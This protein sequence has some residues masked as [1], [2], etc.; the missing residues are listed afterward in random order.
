M[1]EVNPNVEAPKPI[2]SISDFLDRPVKLNISRTYSGIVVTPPTTWAGENG[3][4]RWDLQRRVKTSTKDREG[5]AFS[6]FLGNR[7]VDIFK[8]AWNEG[9][10]TAKDIVRDPAV[11]N[12]VKTN[13]FRFIEAGLDKIDG[14]YVDKKTEPPKI[15][16]Q[17]TEKQKFDLIALIYMKVVDNPSVTNAQGVVEPKG[18]DFITKIITKY[19]SE[20]N[21]YGS[22]GVN[23]QD[24]DQ[25][26]IGLNIATRKALDIYLLAKNNRPLQ[27]VF[28]SLETAMNKGKPVYAKDGKGHFIKKDGKKVPT[29][30]ASPKT[31]LAGAVSGKKP[32]ETTASGLMANMETTKEG[33]KVEVPSLVRNTEKGAEVKSAFLVD[34]I[35][36]KALDVLIP[37]AEMA[38][39]QEY[40]YQAI[41]ANNPDYV[42][43]GVA[44]IKYAKARQMWDTALLDY[45]GFKRDM[46]GVDSLANDKDKN[47]THAEILEI[48]KYTIMIGRRAVEL[49]GE[50]GKLGEMNPIE[51]NKKKTVD[52]V[53]ALILQKDASTQE[54]SLTKEAYRLAKAENA[55]KRSNTKQKIDEP[56]PEQVQA[57]KNE[58]VGEIRK[59]TY[60]LL[61]QKRKIIDRKGERPRFKYDKSLQEL[62]NESGILS[63][64]DSK[65]RKL[66]YTALLNGLKLREDIQPAVDSNP[67]D[68]YN[69][70]LGM[71]LIAVLDKKEG[72]YHSLADFTF[73]QKRN[74]GLK[75]KDYVLRNTMMRETPEEEQFGNIKIT[76]GKDGKPHVELIPAK[77][78]DKPGGTIGQEVSADASLPPAPVVNRENENAEKQKKLDEQAVRVAKVLNINNIKDRNGLL[79]ELKSKGLYK[80]TDIQTNETKIK[81]SI[82]LKTIDVT[83]AVD[84]ATLSEIS[85]LFPEASIKIDSLNLTLPEGNDKT[86][87]TLKNFIVGNLTLS[88]SSAEGQTGFI[89]LERSAVDYIEISK[90]NFVV[91]ID[92]AAPIQIDVKNGAIIDLVASSD[93]VL[94][95]ILTDDNANPK[96]IFKFNDKDNAKVEVVSEKDEVY[97]DVSD[98]GASSKNKWERSQKANGENILVNENGVYILKPKPEAKKAPKPQPAK[99]AEPISQTVSTSVVTEVL[100]VQPT[101][102]ST[103]SAASAKPT[104]SAPSAS[105][106]QP[107]PAPAPQPPPI[108]AAS[109]GSPAPAASSAPSAKADDLDIPGFLRNRRA[110]PSTPTPPVPASAAPAA[111]GAKSAEITVGGNY[112][113]AQLQPRDN[114]ELPDGRK[115]IVSLENGEMVVRYHG[116]IVEDINLDTELK[117]LKKAQEEVKKAQKEVEEEKAGSPGDE[118]VSNGDDVSVS[119]EE[120]IPEWLETLYDGNK[121]GQA[122][123]NAGSPDDESTSVK[124]TADVPETDDVGVQ[125]RTLEDEN[126]ATQPKTMRSVLKSLK[127]R[128]S[129]SKTT[130][131]KPTPDTSSAK[132]LNALP[133]EEQSFFGT[134]LT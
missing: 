30:L 73:D 96:T 47:F 93:D 67:P 18:N 36:G 70:E 65:G 59:K 55:K 131:E 57:K 10:I 6:D 21:K 119:N 42:S 118:Q 105:V 41:P 34:Q 3:I 14:V 74:F 94:K 35:M 113:L 37:P 61:E 102:T 44:M 5:V 38:K 66:V 114:V 81:Q 133:T 85:T 7:V 115:A 120:D 101:P 84:L 82:N 54:D 83:S 78:A 98:P 134:D 89:T 126:E 49:G 33:I 76:Y 9:V 45:Y 90:G 56:K 22:E 122:T 128:F 25:W 112:Y 31:G 106:A 116:Q 19:G 110:Q 109:Q 27:R 125:A 53:V 104:Q 80:D 32:D 132:D 92:G 77:D 71:G 4:D 39:M 107:P 1:Q 11:P 69:G 58:L 8:L 17:L 86:P 43:R 48:Q 91:S 2:R 124:K 100:A 79:E 95:N 68:S 60:Q 62:I 123:K 129:R 46:P 111:S 72:K 108:P 28:E 13:D 87:T 64:L 97:S 23:T 121:R 12:S 63:G 103:D 26:I 40:L 16:E 99:S 117:L 88:G 130:D 29:S 20:V 15:P 50:K 127:D 51:A 24:V 52:L 75:Y